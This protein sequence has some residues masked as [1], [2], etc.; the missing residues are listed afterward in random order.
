MKTFKT[1]YTVTAL[2]VAVIS[3]GMIGC[4]SGSSDGDVSLSLTDSASDQYKAA[5]VTVDKVQVHSEAM[6]GDTWKTIFI[7]QKTYDL[8]ALANGVRES[9]GIVALSAGHYTQM[10]LVLGDTPDN[11]VNILSQS[12]PFANYVIDANDAYHELKVPSGSQTGVKIVQGFDVNA[13]ETTELILDFNV[14]ASVVIAGS[15]GQY[16]LKPTIEVLTTTDFAILS[17]KVTAAADGSALTGALVTAQT[18]DGAAADARDQVEIES[19]TVSTDGGAYALFLRPS[20]YNVVAY[21][22]GYSPAVNA[23]TLVAGTTSTSDFAL[24]AATMGTVTGTVTISG[25]DSETFA[26]LSFRQS[27]MV[28]GSL[29]T[30]EVTP[31]NVAS[32]GNYSISLPSG[33]YTLVSSSANQTTQTSTLTV[34]GGASTLVDVTF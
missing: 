1:I 29:Q 7:P 27:V 2:A 33:S 19:G 28:A 9:L 21:K 3:A 12:H 30:I 25:A 15:S 16:L 11:G 24:A 22:T 26:T 8:L 6:E 5:Y 31:L 14:S 17:G 13:N 4:G 20:S 18:F 23:V 32:G 34:V 10:R